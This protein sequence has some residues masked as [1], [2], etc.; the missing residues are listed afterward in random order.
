MIWID[1]GLAVYVVPVLGVLGAAS[2]DLSNLLHSPLDPIY[3]VLKGYSG[4]GPVFAESAISE[5]SLVTM[6]RQLLRE[7]LGK[8]ALF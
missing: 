3:Q 7:R 5:L 6:M 8:H 2:Y 4:V 1:G